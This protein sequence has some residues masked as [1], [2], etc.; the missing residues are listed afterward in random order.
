MKRCLALDNRIADKYNRGRPCYRLQWSDSALYDGLVRIGLHPA[1]SLTLGELAI[2]DACFADFFRGCIDGDG[3][4]LTYTDRY[5]VS[6]NP[7]YVYRRLYVILFSASRP[8]LD[9]VRSVIQ[10]IVGVCGSIAMSQI[11]NHNPVYDSDTQSV[12]H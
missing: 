8:F 1:K 10:K 9:W 7:L 6:T 3:S 12:S 11:Q 4:I 2:P 5:H